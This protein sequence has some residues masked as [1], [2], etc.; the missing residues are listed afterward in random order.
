VRAGGGE[1]VVAG[2]RA[3]RPCVPGGADH[4]GEGVPFPAGDLERRDELRLEYEQPRVAAFV[5]LFASF[6]SFAAGPGGG[7]D[8]GDQALAAGKPGLDPLRPVGVSSAE[9]STWMAPG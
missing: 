1:R 7:C 6:A 5:A 9:D 4:R 3:Q 8:L 2:Q